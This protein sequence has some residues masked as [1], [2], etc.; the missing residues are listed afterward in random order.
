MRSGY[1][2]VPF[3]YTNPYVLAELQEL[4]YGGAEDIKTAVAALDIELSSED[5]LA[6]EKKQADFA[7]NDELAARSAA[8]YVVG[9]KLIYNIE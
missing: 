4:I 5:N 1:T 6:A 2:K 9:K 3:E 8:L 7:D